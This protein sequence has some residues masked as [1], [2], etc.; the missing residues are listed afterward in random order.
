MHAGTAM[1][2]QS[3]RRDAF[4]GEPRQQAFV[5]VIGQAGHEQPRSGHGAQQ[6]GPG[7][8]HV[9]ADLAEAIEAA[10]R[11]VPIG[12]RRG[13]DDIGRVGGRLERRRDR[14]AQEFFGEQVVVLAGRQD[15]AVGQV[16]IHRRQPRGARVADP[17][18]LQRRRL[19]REHGQP[20]VGRVAGQVDQDVDAI[21]DDLRIQRAVVQARHVAPL[22]HVA[23]QARGDG[24]VHRIVVIGVERQAGPARQARQQRFDERG[25]RMVA[26]VA[27][28]E[29]DAQGAL[30]V[31]RVV[32]GGARRPDARFELLS[33]RAVRSKQRIGADAAHLAHAEQHIAVRISVVRIAR[34]HAAVS[35]DRFEGAALVLQDHRKGITGLRMRRIE[36]E[37]GAGAGM[38]FAQAPGVEQRERH[39][40]VGVGIIRPQ[41]DGAFEH[42]LRV[43]QPACAPQQQAQVA[44]RLGVVRRVLHGDLHRLERLLQI[45][46]QM[47]DAAQQLVAEWMLWKLLG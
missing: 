46:L 10:E 23:A 31:R 6:A 5:T 25:H 13:C 43:G 8:D 18:R 20:V 11:D 9:A 7:G 3:L 27:R 41:R 44:Q 28:D 47:M 2:A 1:K 45:A 29:A 16:V 14:Q 22:R 34:Q 17:G 24:I 33:E 21:G 26:Q 35:L 30:G 36:R 37:R 12:Q 40:V 4:F 19:A 15:E 38:G 42:G 32:P 39:V